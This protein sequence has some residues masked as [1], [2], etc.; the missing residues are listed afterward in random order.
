MK[1]RILSLIIIAVNVFLSSCTK[2]ESIKPVTETPISKSVNTQRENLQNDFIFPVPPIVPIILT[3]PVTN[4][5]TTSAT[6]G[7]NVRSPLGKAVITY[8]ICWGRVSNPTIAGSKTVNGPVSRLFL[9]FTDNFSGLTPNTNYH[10]RAYVTIGSVTY[11]G[12]DESFSTAIGSNCGPVTDID[13]NVYHSITIG[14]QCWMQENLKTTRYNDGTPIP[15]GLSNTQWQT[16]T[17]GAYAIYNDNQANNSIYGKLYN[18]YAVQ[19]G[20]L[21]P[22][23][24][25]VP[26]EAEW[27]TLITYLGGENIAGDK[28]KATVTWVP[29]SGIVNNNSSGFTGLAGGFRYSSGEYYYLGYY[30]NFWT[31]SD[32]YP[33]GSFFRYL[34]YN[35]SYIYGNTGNGKGNG[36][37]VRCIKD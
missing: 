12:N 28:M 35:Y 14:N 37:S 29:F 10:V 13:G 16:T 20:K 27:A 36:F 22:L 11:Y 4:I 9:S 21:A 15:T 32:Y 6:S 34:S 1:T 23:G 19:T 5:T 8:G 3:K 30:G 24:W 18:G 31:S 25:H 7:G 2:T 17:S 33:S 26:T